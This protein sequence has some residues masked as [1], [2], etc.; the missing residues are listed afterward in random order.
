MNKIL[1]IGGSGYIGSRLY[2]HLSNY[3]TVNSV[4]LGWFGI[5][6]QNNTFLD[7]NQLMVK[8][9]VEYTHIILLAG[10]SSVSMCDGDL[11][12]CFS[13][14]VVNFNY[15]LSKLNGNQML[16]YASSAA[17]Y[18][19]NPNLVTEKEPLSSP[20]NYYDYTKLC[21]EYSAKLH[22]HKRTIG[23]RLGTVSGF[24]KNMRIENLLNAISLSAIERN[25]IKISNGG[26]M[27][28]ALGIKDLCRAVEAIIR[29]DT[30]KN[31]IYNLTSINDTIENF[32]RK[33]QKLRYGTTIKN[34]N[35][36]KTGYSFNCS[37][38]LFQADYDFNFLET[39]ES[40]YE[41]ISNN[42]KNIIHSFPRKPKL[43]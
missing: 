27:R 30:I 37:S 16:I 19:N 32:G 40:I 3:Y 18:G 11:N 1:I 41:E 8:D 25:E 6:N 36:L 21:N 20:V 42:Y 12:S 15:L 23:L 31:N 34:D 4:D 22:S 17:V 10:H 29:K 26:L 13:N 14:N 5:T 43:Y 38:E 9:L 39:V 24:S 28:S 2:D 7:Y 35:I 33:V